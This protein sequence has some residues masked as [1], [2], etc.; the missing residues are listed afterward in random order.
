MAR[1]PGRGAR[2]RFPAK[3]RSAVRPIWVQILAPTLT[4]EGLQFTFQDLGGSIGIINGA[5]LTEH[6]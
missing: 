5:H 6:L 4:S 2:K 3:R 1:G